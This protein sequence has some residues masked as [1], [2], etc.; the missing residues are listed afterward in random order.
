M[1][2]IEQI[3]HNSVTAAALSG[4]GGG[5]QFFAR[6]LRHESIFNLLL[7][8]SVLVMGKSTELV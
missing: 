6:F 3:N 8:L 5:D 2:K 4:L 7:D 1:T